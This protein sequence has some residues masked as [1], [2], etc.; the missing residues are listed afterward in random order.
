MS[1]RLVPSSLLALS[2]CLLACH[3][4]DGIPDGLLD[5]LAVSLPDVGRPPDLARP[6]D[7]VAGGCRSDND[8]GPG[9]A[10]CCGGACLDVR[11]DPH[12]CGSCNHACSLP[13][14]VAG[15]SQ[16]ACT[17][18]SCAAGYADCN[19]LVDDGCEVHLA[20]DLGSC[21][22]CGQAC[23][24]SH[25][26][27]GC[28][29]SGCYIRACDFGWDDCDATDATGCE[30][31]VLSDVHNCGGCGNTCPAA[32][33]AKLGC[34]N[35]QCALDA[36]DNGF[37]DCDGSSVNGCETNTLTD[38]NNCGQCGGAC[39]KNLVCIN[40]GCTCNNCNFP[41]ARS[42]CVNLQCVLDACLP[43]FGDCDNIPA[44]GCETL[45]A[46]DAANCGGCGLA[47][48]KNLPVCSDGK[49][50][51]MV[52]GAVMW[53]RAG[54]LQLQDGDAVSLW[55]DASG[56]GNDCVQNSKNRQPVFHTNVL[57]GQPALAFDG[58]D[59]VL[60]IKS[61]TV[62]TSFTF[63][64]VYRFKAGAQAGS[65][66]YPIVFGGDQNVS[67][68]YAGI[69]TL[70]QAGGNSPDVTDIF[71]G[72]GNDARATLKDVS[73]YDQWK[74]FSSVTTVS[75]HNV[76]VRANGVAAVMSGTGADQAMKLT[77]GDA[78]GGGWGGIGGVPT[79]NFGS[80]AAKCD[81]AEVIVYDKALSD[82]ERGVVESY[83]NGKYKVY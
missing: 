51:D 65:V 73:A 37:A 66:Y 33:H 68:Q 28:S 18:A 29:H 48:P 79:G 55:S 83:L 78:N 20:D 10:A 36:C 56:N 8:C 58:L 52:P 67:G 13:N 26:R 3:G 69:E 64:L 14:A 31:T 70:N 7:L 6:P 15:C 22:A 39:A 25:A 21:G 16:G 76:T 24:L 5:D 1:G 30:T 80:Y 34:V 32:P 19:H 11:S 61:T 40:G 77:L 12:R 82:Q 57:N 9:G 74:V 47:C 54:D 43:G 2:C 50:V 72:F 44:N 71:A 23:A 49:C 38:R 53:L 59:D 35:A 75:S 46:S 60:G 4:G 45:T 81:I 62:V 63:L 41:N 27:A 17:I 42:K